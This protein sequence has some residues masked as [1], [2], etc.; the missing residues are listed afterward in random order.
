MSIRKV[1]TPAVPEPAGGIF[2]NCLVV[3]EQVF[4]SGMTASGPDGKAIG[5]DSMEAQ[6]R[7]VFAKIRHLVEAAGA[8]IAD[9][10]KLTIYVTDVARR[11]EIGRA[12]AD[13]FPGEK[14]CSTLIEVKGLV[15][16][17]LLIEVDA[18]AMIGAARNP[19]NQ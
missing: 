10:V 13:A 6:A 2:S 18:V 1:T 11:G 7:A 12:R 16:P 15:A 9:V 5:G 4:L 17:D 3:G 14:P 19:A 8:S